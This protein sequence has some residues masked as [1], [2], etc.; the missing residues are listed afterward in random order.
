VQIF[1]WIKRIQLTSSILHWLSHNDKN[2]NAH[3]ADISQLTYH[4]AMALLWNKDQWVQIFQWT[5]GIQLT[6][7]ILP[8][9]SHTMTKTKIPNHFSLFMTAIHNDSHW[10]SCELQKMEA[11]VST[12]SVD[13]VHSHW[14]KQLVWPQSSS[15][16]LKSHFSSFMT[17]IHKDSHWLSYDCS[18]NVLKVKGDL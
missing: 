9:V 12:E 8:W 4:P 18:Y 2:Q 10:L 15:L 16:C 5:M 13:Q 3:S 14:E 17:E 6:S 11:H 1:E 7:S